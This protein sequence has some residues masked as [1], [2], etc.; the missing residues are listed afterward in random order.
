[1]RILCSLVPMRSPIC[2]SDSPSTHQ[3]LIVV[4]RTCVTRA[5]FALIMRI[6]T[7][8]Y[9]FAARHDHL[10]AV[11][12]LHNLHFGGFVHLLHG[13]ILLIDDLIYAQVR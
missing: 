12:E 2:N 13:Y 1:M 11:L 6:L 10:I 4:R 9:A 7:R 3:T 8:N 5:A